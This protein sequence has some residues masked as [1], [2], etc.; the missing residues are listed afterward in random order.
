M[1]LLCIAS[2]YVTAGY[3]MT[4]DI[5]DGMRQV[6]STSID[7]GGT[8]ISFHDIVYTVNVKDL[9]KRCG[10]LDKEILH[11]IRYVSVKKKMARH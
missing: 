1:S 2:L 5:H 11:S 6:R 3:T 10:S 7:G 8:T 4:A 9:N